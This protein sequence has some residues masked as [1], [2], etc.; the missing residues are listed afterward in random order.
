MSSIQAAADDFAA[1]GH[2]VRVIAVS[3]GKGGVGKTSVAVNLGLALSASGQQ[4]MLL[5]GDLGL[6]NIDV[7]LGLAPRYNL[8]HVMSGERE[9][10]EIVVTTRW[11]L[12]VVP[13]ASG[14]AKMAGLGPSQHLGLVQAFSG[15][16][17]RIDTLIIDTAA[18][19]GDSVLRFCRAAQHRVIVLRD[20]PGSL[21]DAYALIKVLNREHDVTHFKVLVNMTRR[22]DEGARLFNKLEIVAGRYLDVVL[23]HVGDIPEDP[24]LRRAIG[25]QRPVVDA[26]PSSRA[27]LAFAKFSRLAE[28]WPVPRDARGHVEFFVERLLRAPRPLLEVVQ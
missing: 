26:Y 8:S 1:A 18:G 7:A 25:E 15:L 21:T 5:D 13:A 23:E 20:E 22:P 6:A 2:A 19:I 14:I 9:L 4:V 27:A 3:G 12:H 24:Y 17:Q 10:A 16:T 28:R 11:G